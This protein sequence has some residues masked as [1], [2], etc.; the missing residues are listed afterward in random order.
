MEGL[1]LVSLNWGLILVQVRK[2]VLCA[3]VMGIIVGIDG[4]RLKTSDRVKLLDRRCA[5]TCQRTED[6]SFDL[7]HLGKK[8]RN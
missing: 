2:W 5:K 7:C 6:C 3:V 1:E 8:E 4:L